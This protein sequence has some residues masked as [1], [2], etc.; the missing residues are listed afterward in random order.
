MC[1][2]FYTGY[3]WNNTFNQTPS[4]VPRLED[5]ADTKY[6]D[7]ELLDCSLIPKECIS[8]SMDSEEAAEEEEEEEEVVGAEEPWVGARTPSNA[9]SAAV[10]TASQA[11]FLDGLFA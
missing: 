5:H 9:S 1:Q 10:E 4:F 6:F 2:P 7:T 8:S 11:D 3:D